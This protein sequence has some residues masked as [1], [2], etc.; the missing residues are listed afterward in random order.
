VHGA[1]DNA[2]REWA[3]PNEFQVAVSGEG[4]AEVPLDDSNLAV[5]AARLLARTYAPHDSL[6][7]SLSIKKSIPVA[8]GLAGGSANAAAALV[9]CAVLWD[10][11]VSPEGLRTLA[12]ELGSDVPFFLLGG[13]AVGIGRGTEI[14]PLPD[15]PATHGLLLAPGIHVNTAQAYRDLSPR[16][17][18]DLQRNKIYSF[19]SLTWDARSFSGLSNDFEAVV[20]EQHPELALLKRRLVRAGASVALMTGSGSSVFGLLQY[21]G[22]VRTLPLDRRQRRLAGWDLV[23]HNDRRFHKCERYAHDGGRLCLL[24]QDH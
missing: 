19:Q 9:A 18:T 4:A 11:D 5:R 2:D 1:N 24:G 6:G 21:N 23:Q 13:A 7:A 20:F 8:G 16:L 14:F 15:L 10:L 12:A 17:T 3:N 22:R